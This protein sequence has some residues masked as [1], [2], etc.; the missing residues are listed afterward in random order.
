[1]E[2][3]IRMDLYEKYLHRIE[4]EFRITIKLIF[5][6]SKENILYIQ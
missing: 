2:I 3:E 1:M 4:I 5:K 6:K